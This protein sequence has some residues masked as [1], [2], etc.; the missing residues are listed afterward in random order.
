MRRPDQQAVQAELCNGAF[1]LPDKEVWFEEDT[2]PRFAAHL[3]QPVVGQRGTDEA[4]TGVAG[5]FHVQHNGG[6]IRSSR[7]ECAD[8]DRQRCRGSVWAREI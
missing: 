7:Y 1:C 5:T 4:D 8:P 2:L 3:R 6:Y